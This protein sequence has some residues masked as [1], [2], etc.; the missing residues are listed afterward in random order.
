MTA[1]LT[2]TFYRR[3]KPLLHRRIARELGPA[4]RVLDI[5]C[6]DCTL[7]GPL[8]RAVRQEVIGVD[9]S[10]GRFPER[11]EKAA[12]RHCV[13]ADAR[14]LDF[15]GRES[16]DAVVSVW[17]LHELAAPM[18]VL[19]EARRLLRP[20]GEILV[21]DFPRGSLAQRLWNE[22]YYTTGEVA[23][24]LKR[25]G[26]ARVQARRIARRQLTWARGFKPL[27]GRASSS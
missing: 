18:A 15:L 17:V 26:F 13:K 27:R 10:D 1:P 11:R 4:R 12:G 6:G 25:A 14:S 8:A 23:D 16:I 3:Y 22:G 24:M 5:G 7:A 9:I 20:G 19:R 2:R 21:V